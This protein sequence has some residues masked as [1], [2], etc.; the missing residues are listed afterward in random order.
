VI[1][2]ANED[3]P[4]DEFVA[5]QIAG[6][7]LRPGDEAAAIATAFCLSGPDMPDINR[8]EERRH[9]LLNEMTSTVATVFLGLQM[10]CAQCHHHK[11]DPISQADFYRLRSFFEPAVH[12]ERDKSVFRLQNGNTDETSH[13]WIRG[14]WQRPGP[15]IEAAF[16]RIATLPGDGPPPA[17][18]ARRAALARWLVEDDNPLT[19]R[20]IA[21]R[22]WQFHF[23]R[24]LCESASDF[25][26]AGDEPA[27]PELLDWLACELVQS[28]WQ[29]KHLHRLI[30]TSATYQQASRRPLAANGPAA[31][32]D[33]LLE[34]DPGNE[35]WGRFPRRRLEGEAIRDAMLDV[36]GYLNEMAGG[37]G[38]R[39]PIAPEL[40]AT[41]LKGQWE[42]SPRE[43]D[44]YRRSIYVFARRN[45]RYPLFDVF[46]R[47]DANATCSRRFQSTTAPQ[48]LF[49]LNSSFAYEMAQ[50]LGDRVQ[51]ESETQE[52]A[53]ARAFR[54]A[55]GRPPDDEELTQAL[56]FL[57]RSP[58]GLD[59]ASRASAFTD[60]CLA[61]LN[62][63]EFLYID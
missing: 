37:P 55:W 45:L 35:L 60:F 28:G 30:L 41:L 54:C 49:M 36:A 56:Q 10:G 33:E 24:G 15:V 13:I 12:V 2:A 7:E 29:L 23:G 11:F 52:Q 34:R 44:H 20:V 27:H 59:E 6:D 58:T 43:A 1:Q 25:G 31:A 3:V 9:Y 38:I 18:G 46:D 8:Q 51:A 14:D 26:Y 53:V 21:N 42:V 48:A 50:H 17:D 63:N 16:P 5:L 39:P 62:A 61:L 19:A 22:V 4:Y 57:A 40:Q 47:P 32:W